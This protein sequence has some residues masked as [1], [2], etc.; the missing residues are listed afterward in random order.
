MTEYDI[1]LVKRLMSFKRMYLAWGEGEKIDS[2]IRHYV[3]CGYYRSKE[4][5]GT[6]PCTCGLLFH[7]QKI[8]EDGIATKIYPSFWDEWSNS[9]KTWEEDQEFKKETPE[10]R[11]AKNKKIDA[12]FEKTFGKYKKQ[13]EETPEEIAER[14]K[15]E[16]QIIELAFGTEF[17][18]RMKNL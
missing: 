11:E 18:D 14:D 1:K 4:V 6:S 2:K 10:E 7:L 16:W 9:E 13:P 8:G 17:V 3:A 12:L 15:K 5:Y